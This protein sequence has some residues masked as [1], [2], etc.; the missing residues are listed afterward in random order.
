MASGSEQ[1]SKDALSKLLQMGPVA[2]FQRQS[3]KETT[4][5]I[6]S[7]LSEVASPEIKG[8]LDA[9]EDIGVDEVNNVIDG[10]FV[11]G[12][13][14]MESMEVSSKFGEFSENK[15]SVE[16]VVVGGGEALGVGEDDD[17]GNV[18]TDGGNGAVES[19]D[20]SIL[21]SLFG[22]ESP[23]VPLVLAAGSIR[24]WHRQN[25]ATVLFLAINTKPFIMFSHT[26][27]LRNTL[28]S[29]DLS[30]YFLHNLSLLLVGT[31]SHSSSSSRMSF[32]SPFNNTNFD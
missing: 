30:L 25:R 1:D 19:G 26:F 12:E 27:S 15:E 13:S 16:E 7:L 28:L 21:I 22:H 6:T 3:I 20:I 10:A 4:D 23:S 32:S 2:E 9:D 11:I 29:T 14:N 5:T 17:T 8:S 18:A 24:Q 31:D